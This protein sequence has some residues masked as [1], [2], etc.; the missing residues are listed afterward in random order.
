M[1]HKNLDILHDRWE[2]LISSVLIRLHQFQKLYNDLKDQKPSIEEMNHDAERLIREA[3][4]CMPML[5]I[6]L[7]SFLRCAFASLGLSFLFQ[8]TLLFLVPIST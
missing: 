7:S 4:V 2:V 8:L 3:K 6:L 5:F 1:F